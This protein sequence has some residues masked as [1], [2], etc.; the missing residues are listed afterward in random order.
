MSTKGRRIFGALPFNTSVR[1]R[2][3]GAWGKMPVAVKKL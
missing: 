1:G 2:H 3:S